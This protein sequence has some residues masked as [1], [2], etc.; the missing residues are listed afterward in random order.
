MRGRWRLKRNPAFL[1]VVSLAKLREKPRK[2]L[3][4]AK[5]REDVLKLTLE[6]TG[7]FKII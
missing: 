3:F 6:C 1:N 2:K 5:K 7:D 4:Y